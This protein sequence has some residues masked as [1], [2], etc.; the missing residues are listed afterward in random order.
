MQLFPGARI[1]VIG[2]G[3]GGLVTARHALAAGFDVT[4]FE[5]SDDLGGQWNST[6][7]H[8]GIW[9]GMRTN[10][11][12][13]ITAFSE[14]P[15]PPE[16]GMFPLAE[17]I[18]AYLRRYADTF[19]V[20]PRIRFRTAV[21]SVERGWVVDGE[22]FDAVV[23]AS[24]RFRA[25]RLPAGLAQFDGELLHAFDHPGAE[26]LRGRRVLVY[27]NGVSGHE[28]ASDVATVN[29]G[30]PPVVSAYRKP[31]YVLQKLVDGVPSDGRWY[32]HVA[33][34]QRRA[35]PTAEWS[36][37]LRDRIVRLSGHPAD[38]GAPAPDEDLLVAGHSLCQDYLEQVRRGEI[39]C[40]PGIASVDG[41]TVTFTD[42]STATV[43]V[44]IA[45]TGY[46]LDLPY[47]SPALKAILGPQ[48]ALH[49]RTWH[50]ELLGFA[51]VGQF[52]L[53][54]PYFP[55]LELQARWLTGVW[56]GAVA[57]PTDAAMRA[58]VAGPPPPID[59]HHVLALALAEQGGVAPDLAR[60]PDLAEPLLFGPLLPLRYRLDGPGSQAGA[61]DALRAQFAATPRAPV[62]PD[63][64]AMLPRLD[65]PQ[66]VVAAAERLPRPRSA[67]HRADPVT[68]GS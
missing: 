39:V 23:V 38:V 31:R 41:R 59:S 6:A 54:G 37:L 49:L 68:P 53:Q 7:P 45:A 16:H 61:E 56:S 11:S 64:L 35:L 66:A 24:G 36:G 47:L 42:S 2:A 46:D 62:E 44:I 28:V 65:L 17:Q 9:P 58:S 15:P 25:P 43:D 60:H 13:M 63:D 21:G 4:V 27:G 18:H 34:L 20:T 32:T 3:P 30:D 33:A 5:A 12:R 14:L 40:R 51:A 26:A 29:A 50:P 55:L 52:A 67:A 22:P 19:D 57:P 48:L 1:A 10:T 8:S